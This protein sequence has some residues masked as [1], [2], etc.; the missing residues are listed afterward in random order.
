MEQQGTVPPLADDLHARLCGELRAIDAEFIRRGM[1]A[2]PRFVDA[3]CTRQRLPEEDMLELQR[4]M[5]GQA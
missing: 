4:M 2:N 3:F 1:V 5:R